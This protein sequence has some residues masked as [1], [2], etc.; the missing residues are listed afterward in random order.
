MLDFLVKSALAAPVDIGQKYGPAKSFP[1]FGDLVNVIVRN[2]LTIAGIIAL[3]AV[4]IAG[5]QIISGAGK[6]EGEKAA[7][8]AGAFTAAVVGIIIIFSA[9]FIV[10]IIE[11]ILGYPILNPNF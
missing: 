10:Q 4:I 11:K 7:K 5:F 9:Y 6:M 3:V 2:I 8:G 1:S